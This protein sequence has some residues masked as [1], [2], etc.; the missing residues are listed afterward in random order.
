MHDEHIGRAPSEKSRQVTVTMPDEEWAAV[1]NCI[2]TNM[3][4]AD[5]QY[6]VNLTNALGNIAI[7]N[8][9]AMTPPPRKKGP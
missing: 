2:M 7:A 1:A 6:H 9:H 4:E 8:L 3:P 5:T